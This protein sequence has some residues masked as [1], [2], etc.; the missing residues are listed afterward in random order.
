VSRLGIKTDRI[1]VLATFL[2]PFAVYMTTLTPTVSFFDS[3]ELISG[4][5]TLGISHPPGYPLYVL[6]GHV[7]SYIPLG[8]IAFRVNTASA[9]FGALAVMVLYLITLN[10][11]KRLFTEEKEQLFIKMAALSSSLMFAFSLNQWGQTNMSEVYALNTFI[12]ALLILTTLVWH[13]YERKRGGDA[14]KGNAR[15]FY[16]FAFIFGLGF[17]DHHTILVVVPV[18]F[19]VILPTR[20][21]YLFDIKK[22][23]LCLAFFTL[24][25]SVYLYMPVRATTDL[26]MNWGNPETWEQFSWMFFREGYPKGQVYRD[27]ALFWEQLQTI[28]LLYE[29]TLVGFVVAIIGLLRFFRQGWLF[30]LISFTV[31]GVLSVGLIIYSSAPRENIFLYEAFH[32]PTYMVF[33][34]WI[35]VGLFWVL[36]C[37]RVAGKR[38]NESAYAGKILIA[39]WLIILAAMPALPFYKHFKKNDRSR[40]FIAY[41]YASNSLKSLS[42]NGILFTWGDS[43][44]F[45]LWYLNYVEK[46]KPG[47]LLLHTPHLASDWYVDEIADLKNSR[48]RRVAA[49]RRSPGMVVEYITRENLG[50]RRSYIDYS[51]RYS[52]PIRKLHFASHGV[53]YRNKLEGEKE[54]VSI[55]ESYIT[56]GLTSSNI[57]K[58]LDIGK[59]IAIYGFCRYDSGAALISQGLRAEGVKQLSEAIKIVPGLRGKAQN[60]LFPRGRAAR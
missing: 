3:G 13:D 40:N 24:G 25:F 1:L 49:K 45:P 10:V 33:A 11:M 23:S 41:D 34:P 15:L 37:L 58:D 7:F 2:I 21:Q 36:I 51:S 60:L 5:A 32:T 52:Y 19:F 47:T 6:L 22:L 16:F 57:V 12:V 46:Y 44:A 27:W 28:N 31:L 35:G 38:L 42:P 43:G 20:W 29:Y 50:K 9:F 54:D 53:V 59:A 14:G 8:N 4:A 56:R 39:L 30:A 18:G 55:W 26:I 48:I 17:G